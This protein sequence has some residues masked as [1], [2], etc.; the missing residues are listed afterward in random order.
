ME[1]RPYYHGFAWAYDLLNAEPIA[2]RVDFIVA[3]L[4]R[5]GVRSPGRLL[6]AGC[7]SGRYAVALAARGFAVTGID[8]SSELI[9]IAR[10]KTA[11]GCDIAFTTANLLAFDAPLPF[12]AVL[13]RGV[14]NDILSDDDREAIFRRF[15]RWLSPGGILILDVRDWTRS[16]ARYQANPDFRRDIRLPNGSVLVFTSRTSLDE[17]AQVLLV[18]ERFEHRH[19]GER[20]VVEHDF[21]MRCWSRDELHEMMGG[22]FTDIAIGT[23][24]GDND[25][26]WTDRIVAIARR[27]APSP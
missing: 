12:A 7:G 19:G 9:G 18:H 10:A 23:G 6:D 21:A 15:A 17:T 27:A 25:T 4:A 16:A 26:T 8:Q 11:V 5:R 24:Y 1:L 2:A 14:L 3:E 20:T 13:C 22:T